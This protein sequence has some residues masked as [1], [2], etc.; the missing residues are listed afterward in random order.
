MFL[1][2]ITNKMNSK[3]R[4]NLTKAEKEIKRRKQECFNCEEKWVKGHVCKG[5]LF[6]LSADG[7]PFTEFNKP[8]GGEGFQDVEQEMQ[9]KG[10]QITYYALDGK[11]R[12]K[13]VR[14][15]AQVGNKRIMMLINSGSSH[16]FIQLEV[17]KYLHLE[18]NTIDPFS[19]S[20]GNGELRCY[21]ICRGVEIV[22]ENSE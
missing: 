21:K 1:T 13:T 10:I 3:V 12:P 16:N 5:K 2:T 19:V 8:N 11:I 14:V 9:P 4:V 6:L 7:H 22:W 18:F 15:L 17:S 20:I